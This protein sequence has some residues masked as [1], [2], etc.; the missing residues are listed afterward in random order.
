MAIEMYESFGQ[1]DGTFWRHEEREEDVC[2]EVEKI[3]D[4]R[5]RVTTCHYLLEDDVKIHCSHCHFLLIHEEG[6][7]GITPSSTLP[8]VARASTRKETTTKHLIDYS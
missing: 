7:N 4:L 3:Y 8:H 5:A 1:Q 6:E 2:I